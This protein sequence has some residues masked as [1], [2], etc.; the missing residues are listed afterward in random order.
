MDFGNKHFPTW[1]M[2][3]RPDFLD[4]A[5]TNPISGDICHRLIHHAPELETYLR[6]VPCKESPIRVRVG[7]SSSASYDRLK[8]H[9]MHYL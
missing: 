8:E 9:T 4:I 2:G 3:I 1:I 6:P 5:E 7:V